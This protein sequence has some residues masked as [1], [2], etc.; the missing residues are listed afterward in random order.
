MTVSTTARYRM[1]AE[2]GVALRLWLRTHP[3][4]RGGT[5]CV[6]NNEVSISV[7]IP[8]GLSSLNDTVGATSFWDFCTTICF[9]TFTDAE[10]LICEDEAPILMV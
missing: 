5:D 1:G 9:A 6:A 3:L 4:R 7:F 2:L 8:H 10:L